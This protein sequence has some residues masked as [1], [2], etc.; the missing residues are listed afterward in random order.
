MGSGSVLESPDRL[1]RELR[2]I[3]GFRKSD[4]G[5][6]GACFLPCGPRFRIGALGK[7]NQ[8][9]QV[10]GP[11]GGRGFLLRGEDRRALDGALRNIPG[12]LGCGWCLTGAERGEGQS[13]HGDQAAGSSSRS[14]IVRLCL[15]LE[16][17]ADRVT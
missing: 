1:K 9:G 10:I 15:L 5:G 13:S 8:L 7:I 11:P 3:G 16:G 6:G 4:A 2:Q 14:D 12:T 17:S